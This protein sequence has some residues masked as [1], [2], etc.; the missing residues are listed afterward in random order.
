MLGKNPMDVETI[1]IQDWSDLLRQEPEFGASVYRGH[2][3]ASW[4]LETSLRRT[5]TKFSGSY[6]L[7]EADFL[8]AER[9]GLKTFR[10]RAHFYLKDLPEAADAAS[11][12]AIMQH[13]GTPTR[14]LDF[15]RSL[16]VAVFF[17][18]IDATSDACVWAIDDHWLRESGSEFATEH[19]VSL[20]NTLRYGQLEAM[21]GAAN[22]VINT[23]YFGGTEE[24]FPDSAVLMIELERQ[25]P[26]LAA[27]QGLFLL[28][29]QLG[30]TFMDNLLGMR[31][32]DRS[33]PKVAKLLISHE[34]RG[35]FLMHLRAMNI[36]AES[37]FPGLE[38][39]AKSLIQY[40][41]LT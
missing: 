7:D 4:S 28:P 10:R 3:D 29:T 31:K 9:A 1:K 22:N 32:D 38:G 6:S 19:G 11:W 30:S 25:I 21:Y 37:L 14:L 33:R 5:I 36:T 34:H 15:T 39:F 26:Q 41:M 24:D 23:N 12:L 17:A 18:L 2:S 13:H 8:F 20:S 40:D 35:H 16:Y 27:Q